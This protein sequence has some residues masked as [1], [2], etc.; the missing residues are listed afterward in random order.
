MLSKVSAWISKHGLLIVTSFLLG[1]LVLQTV[2]FNTQERQNAAVQAEFQRQSQE[3]QVLREAAAAAQH[4]ADILKGQVVV[5]DSAVNADK[6]RKARI[7]KVKDQILAELKQIGPKAA[8]LE[9]WQ[10]SEMATNIIDNCDEYD[11]PV[12]LLMGLIRQ[13]SAFNPNAVSLAGAQGLT[14]VMPTTASDIKEWMGRN[15]Y[16]PFKITHNIKFGAYYLNR[17]LRKFHYDQQKA[18]WAYN[19]GPEHVYQ[20]TAGAK[21]LYKEPREYEEAIAAYQKEFEALGIN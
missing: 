7:V 12:P 18:L 13:E 3:L 5:I 1:S 2:R 11:I 15:Y 17:M 9:P 19:A 20:V 21:S 6:K 4:Q 14:Q 8:A 10:V 16:D